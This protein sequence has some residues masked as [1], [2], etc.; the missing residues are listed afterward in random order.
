M[1]R[2]VDFNIAV[3]E[4]CWHMELRPL[5]PK[6]LETLSTFVSGKD[7]FVALPTGYRKSIIFVELP[8]LFDI[9]FGKALRNNCLHICII[10]VVNVECAFMF[11]FVMF[12]ATSLSI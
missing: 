12:T 9:L 11:R 8:L 5:R 4:V 3:S 2:S 7:T 6:Q 10:I 1:D